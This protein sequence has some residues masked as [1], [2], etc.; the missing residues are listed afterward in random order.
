MKTYSCFFFTI[1]VCLF[2]LFAVSGCQNSAKET[3]NIGGLWDLT[4]ST[5]D[6]ATPYSDGERAYI[7]YINAKGGINGQT[8]VLSYEDYA[9]NIPRAEEVYDRLVNDHRVVAILGWGT[10]DSL[11]LRPR[12]A[13][14]KIPFFSCSYDEDLTKSVSTS[15]NFMIGVTYS[16]QMRIALRYINEQWTDKTRR[17]RVA[18][19]YNDTPFGLSPIQVG[20]DYAAAHGIEI[21]GEQIV[22]L[23]ALDAKAQI[24]AANSKGE[25]DFAIINETSGATATIVR[26][27]YQLGVK[28]KFIALNWG[29][30]ETV[31]RM[32]GDAGEGLLGTA[33]FAFPYENLPGMDEIRAAL[34][35]LGKDE[36]VLNLRFVQGWV[37]AKVL[38]AGVERAGKNPTGEKIRRALESMDSY[39]TGGVTAPISF[40]PTRH[41]GATKL[42]IYQIKNGRWEPV[43]D[44]IEATP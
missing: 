2:G 28:T 12:V 29:V 8:V 9:Y 1:V 13:K 34:K 25:A 19:F 23:S 6:A 38:M 15:Y 24:I 16:D 32:L 35:L 14:D 10:G 36:K 3:I 43:T 18:F 39:D 5:S 37:T 7:E 44:Y 20:R 33:P 40:S 17:P 4:G 42:K 30:D 27:A 21:V 41:K 22:A 31:L 11:A 26:S